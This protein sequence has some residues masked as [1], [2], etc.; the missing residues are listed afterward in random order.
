MQK[1]QER[2]S[3]FHKSDMSPKAKEKW[4]KVLQPDV[5]SSEESGQEGEDMFVRKLPWRSE[6]VNN[7]FGELDERSL[8][9]KT[10]QAKRQRKKRMFSV[11]VSARSPP[12]GLPK[13]A[14]SS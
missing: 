8:E 12:P 2:T 13:W 6:L 1:L 14:I 5:M 9:K 7:F 11:N 3:I 4:S 10:A